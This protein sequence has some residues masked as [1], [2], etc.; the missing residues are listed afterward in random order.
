MSKGCTVFNICLGKVLKTAKF[1]TKGQNKILHKK[2]R[3]GKIEA[4]VILKGADILGYILCI[5]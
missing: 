4:E 3:R 1:T 2:H 5:F